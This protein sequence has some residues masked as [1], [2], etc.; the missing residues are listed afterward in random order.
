MGYDKTQEVSL[1]IRHHH[2]GLAAN[3]SNVRIGRLPSSRVHNTD[4]FI[5]ATSEYCVNT[6]VNTCMNIQ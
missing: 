5:S 1:A 4:V 6:T 2:V 3:M